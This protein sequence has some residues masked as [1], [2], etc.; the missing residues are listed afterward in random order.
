MEQ[1]KEKNVERSLRVNERG[2]GEK[3]PVQY[4]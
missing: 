2:R 3:L 1:K 4:I